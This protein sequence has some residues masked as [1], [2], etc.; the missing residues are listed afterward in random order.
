[1]KLLTEFLLSI[2]VAH[3]QGSQTVTVQNTCLSSRIFFS[4]HSWGVTCSIAYLESSIQP[5][6]I[7]SCPARRLREEDDLHKQKLILVLQGGEILKTW[8]W[9]EDSMY[10]NNLSPAS[11]ILFH[12]NAL[13]SSHV[14]VQSVNTYLFKI[15]KIWIT[16][17]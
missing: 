7:V 16:L 14:R 10:T 1:M 5:Q 2:I 13:S 6:Q 17:K 4:H 15:T 9:A 12:S 3:R 8:Q 11:P